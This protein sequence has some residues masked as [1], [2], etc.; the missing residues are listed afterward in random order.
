MD[1]AIVFGIVGEVLFSSKDSKIQGELRKRS[2]E[3]A[4]NFEKKAAEANAHAEEANRLAKEADLR[5]VELQA[6]I[7]DRRLSMQDGVALVMALQEKGIP[8]LYL[9]GLGD[10]EALQYAQDFF[11]PLMA[12][13]LI[14][15]LE[16]T[17]AMPGTPVG[18]SK[19]FSNFGFA[20]SRE[21]SWI[22][23]VE[24]YV[25]P[26]LPGGNSPQNDPLVAALSDIGIAARGWS[27]EWPGK[28]ISESN[29][30]PGH[31]ILI[32]GAKPRQK[33]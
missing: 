33:L 10:D 7:A 23:G 17:T 31:R 6:K 5:R 28:P 14:E 18:S 24:V 27:K 9:K 12:N 16:P 25:P 29:W 8:P 3:R 22:K 11:S 30:V 19:T 2:N 21:A 26:G 20:M 1:A 15:L 4:A 32:I 13:G